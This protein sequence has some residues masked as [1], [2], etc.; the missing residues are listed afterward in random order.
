MTLFKYIHPERIDVIRNL[1]D[2]LHAEVFCRHFGNKN[3]SEIDYQM[4]L[5]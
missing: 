2:V 4:I 1:D 5:W 3:L